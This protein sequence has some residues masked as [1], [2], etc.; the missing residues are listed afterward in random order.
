MSDYHK[1]PCRCLTDYKA[2]GRSDPNCCACS[3]G[4]N[5]LVGENDQLKAQVKELE[6][7]R[8]EA[9]SQ[10]HKA[11]SLSSKLVHAAIDGKQ[12]I[13]DEVDSE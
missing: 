2:I 13:L 7:E 10:M 6:R 9:I 4:W 8:D 1:E 3:C 5:E 12:L 11:Q